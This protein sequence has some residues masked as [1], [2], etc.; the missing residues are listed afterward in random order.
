M[1][2]ILMERVIGRPIG[3]VWAVLARFD[4]ISAWASN[5]DH[6]CLTTTQADGVGAI[7]RIQA[8]RTTV[9][10]RIVEWEPG[11]VLAY[12][13]DGLPPVVRGVVN[14]WELEADGSTTLVRLRTT[15]TPGPR[16][17]HKLAAAAVGKVM[18]KASNQML[19]G[20]QAH[21]EGQATEATR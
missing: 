10:E 4:A 14:R 3:D 19:A 11:A 18:T 2:E 1:A 13:I 7:R 21:V 6:S 8:G 12:E 17:P 5:V 9:L 20:L 15:I 16:P